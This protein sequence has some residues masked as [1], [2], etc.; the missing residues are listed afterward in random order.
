M[1]TITLWKLKP[2]ENKHFDLEP[3][4]LH[5]APGSLNAASSHIP[6]GVYTT[7]RTFDGSKILPLK[8]QIDRLEE[9][10]GL[11]GVRLQLNQ[12]SILEALKE[13]MRNYQGRDLRVRVTVDLE[14]ERGTVYLAFEPLRMPS[15]ED[16]ENGVSTITCQ[17]Q[18]KIPQ[19]KRTTFIP[20]A[21]ALKRRL[22]PGVQE[23]LL[24]DEA[25]YILEGLSSNFFAVKGREIYTAGEDVLSGITRSLVLQA[26]ERIP[27]MVKLQSVHASEIPD[28]EE[29]FLTGSS[30]SVL[31]VRQIDGQVVGEGCPGTIT[32]LI[33]DAYGQELRAKLVDLLL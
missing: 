32:K 23:G 10:A 24:V 15:K 6:G 28:L 9:S 11:V 22:P 17:Y 18:R 13:A 3:I 19:S 7:F 1:P 30:R 12:P 4:N 26:A 21:E 8:Y 27:I 31:P 5:P 29:A 20:V 16:Y 25:G 33:S 14:K 2:T